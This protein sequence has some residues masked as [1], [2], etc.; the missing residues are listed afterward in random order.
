[1]KYRNKRL[2]R[3][4]REIRKLGSRLQSICDSYG[5]R[6]E[7]NPPRW[8]QLKKVRKSNGRIYR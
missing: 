4:H 6:A 7:K 5:L 1:M 3:L 2:T 8:R